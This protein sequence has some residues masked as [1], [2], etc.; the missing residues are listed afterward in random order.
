MALQFGLTLVFAQSVPRSVAEDECNN[1][2]VPLT[3]SLVIL[4]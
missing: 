4:K 1:D 2:I 3:T